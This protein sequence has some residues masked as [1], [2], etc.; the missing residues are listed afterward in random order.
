MAYELGAIYKK[1]VKDIDLT[2]KEN[3]ENIKDEFKIEIKTTDCPLFLAKKRSGYI[4][5]RFLQKTFNSQ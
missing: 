1:D 4:C 5:I 2:Y 3:K